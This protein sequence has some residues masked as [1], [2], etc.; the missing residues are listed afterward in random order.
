[1]KISDISNLMK[2]D[3]KVSSI[4]TIHCQSLKSSQEAELFGLEKLTEISSKEVARRLLEL[5]SHKVTENEEGIKEESLLTSEDIASITKVELELF[6]REFLKKNRWMLKISEHEF[7]KKG[8]DEPDLDFLKRVFVHRIE[9]K[10]NQYERLVKSSLGPLYSNKTLASLMQNVDRSQQ[11]KDSIARAETKYQGIDS[12]KILTPHF[13]PHQQKNP[14]HETNEI[15]GD[16]KQQFALISPIASQCAD[17]IQSMNDTAINMQADYINNASN[18]DVQTKKAIQI[19]TRS[20]W[21]SIA[22][23]ILSAAFSLL[24][25]IDSKDSEKKSAAQIKAFQT[26]MQEMLKDQREDRAAIL[27][28]QNEDRSALMNAIKENQSKMGK[29]KNDSNSPKSIN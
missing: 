25:F 24:T 4:G 27:K 3:F 9:A 10:K 5:I 14:I 6:S 19:A 12:P 15:L 1:M 28:Q 17:L 7:L 23:L 8:V 18:N 21:V 11:L 16:L 20:M 29:G 2:F 22:S 13:L 26:E